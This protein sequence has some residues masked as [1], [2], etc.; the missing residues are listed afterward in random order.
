[1]IYRGWN[2]GY[3]RLVIMSH[4]KSYRTYYAHNS[5][6]GRRGTVGR[7]GTIAY[8]GSTGHSTGPHV[9]FEVRR[10]GTKR[11][12]PASYGSY[13]TKGRGIPYNY[14]GI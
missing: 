1:M 11:Y 6:Y 12:I 13:K 7:G 3:G 10:Y 14:S 9:H 4:A 2:G 8:C 5:R